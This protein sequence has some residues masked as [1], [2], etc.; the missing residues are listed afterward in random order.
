MEKK[1]T[2]SDT[3]KRYHTQ[4]YF[5]RHKFGGKVIKV[6]LNGGF[7]CPNKDGSK[8]FGG[9]TYCSASGSGDFGGNPSKPIRQQFDE[10]KDVLGRKWQGAMYIP[11][12]QANTNTY[13]PT[14]RLRSMFEE[15]LTFDGVVGI[16]IST[17]PDCITEETADYLGGL[18]KRTYLTV[19]L[20]LQTA[21]DKTAAAINRCHTYADFLDGYEMLR[22]RNVNVCVHV[23][24]GLPGE[25]E[26]MMLETAKKISRLDIH[27]VKIHLLHIISGTEIAKQYERGEFEALSFEK[28]INIVCSQI[29]L[30]PPEVIIE[31][32]TGD[33]DRRTLISPK[34]SLDKKRVMN[35]IDKEFVRRGSFQGMKFLP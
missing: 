4:N 14:E 21:F 18:A 22:K 3:N 13:A 19:E 32:I 25:T 35:G 5:L 10:M 9:C 1:I 30:L 2:Y 24:N 8:G 33:G 23:I 31:R 27:A 7:T 12:F 28:Y 29:E 16:A 6:S 26:E 15:A 20:G 34:W 11:Y 17:R